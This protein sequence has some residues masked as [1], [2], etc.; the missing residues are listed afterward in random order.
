MIERP[1]IVTEPTNAE[2]I[3]S[4]D[5]PLTAQL[6]RYSLKHLQKQVH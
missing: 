2:P 6:A 3:D 5:G 1:S 4:D